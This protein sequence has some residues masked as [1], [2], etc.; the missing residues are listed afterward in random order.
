M[1][2]EVHWKRLRGESDDGWD[3]HRV[4]YAY[5]EPHEGYFLYIGKAYGESSSV[6]RRYEAQDKVVMRDFF[7]DQLD[8]RRGPHVLV[9]DLAYDGNAS[10]QLFDDVESLLIKRLRPV[11]NT[12]CKS[13]R[14]SRPG[15]RVHC[16][17]QAWPHHR[18]EFHDRG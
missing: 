15:L 18:R 3:M 10:R 17:G 11:C 5:L 14:I 7:F 16:V 8:L 9:G 4:L 13:S 1:D 6:R 12:S 2:V